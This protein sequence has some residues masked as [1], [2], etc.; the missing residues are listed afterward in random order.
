M[1]SCDIVV[2]PHAPVEGFVGSPMKIFEYMASGRAIV[3]SR[4]EQIGEVLEHERTAILVEP[5]DVTEL[6]KALGRLADDPELRQ[7][8][9]RAAQAAARERHTWRR[10]MEALLDRLGSD[11]GSDFRSPGDKFQ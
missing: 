5:G 3:A 9:G 8:L 10:R 1:A 11:T 2:S 7:R 4:L 6:A